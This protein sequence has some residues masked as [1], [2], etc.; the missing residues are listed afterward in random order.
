MKL[1]N[2]F[3]ILIFIATVLVVVACTNREIFFQYFSFSN[4]EWNHNSPAV[5]NVTIDD[6]T[7]VYDV[8]IMLRNSDAYPFRNI[9]LLIDRKAPDGSN[10]TDTISADLVTP[11]G[12]WRGSGLSLYNLSIPYETDVLYPDTGV[13]VY[14]VRQGMQVNPL[15]GISDVGLKV[16]KKSVE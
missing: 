16:S 1:R 12:K 10:H 15:K 8:S 11:H 4:A 13:Y 6:N 14:A 5:F 3:F 7:K 2:T 9:W